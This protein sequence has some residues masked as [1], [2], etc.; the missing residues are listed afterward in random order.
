[1]HLLIRMTAGALFSKLL[2][3]P[4]GSFQGTQT[5]MSKTWGKIVFP[6][7]GAPTELCVCVLRGTQS[8]LSLC[9]SL[10][11]WRKSSWTLYTLR[12]VSH[13][14]L[15]LDPFVKI[16][17]VVG[18]AALTVWIPLDIYHDVKR[19][20]KYTCCRD[21]NAFYYLLKMWSVNYVCRF[22]K[23]EFWTLKC[24][25]GLWSVN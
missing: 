12:S 15:L 13:R 16:M 14:T 11:W 20:T 4:V 7:R 24:E 5:E 9:L 1:M 3:P 21:T 10:S 6:M 19:V 18:Y 17:A 22:T 2:I 25:V 23:R 8:S